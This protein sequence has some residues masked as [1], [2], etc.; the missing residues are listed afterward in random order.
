MNW[1]RSL[2]PFGVIF[3]AYGLDRFSKWWAADFLA[4]NGPTELHS[5]LSIKEAYNRGIAFGMFQGIGPLVGWL[6]IGV[7]IVLTISMLRL[8]EGSNL[9]KLG[10]SILIGGALG[11]MWDRIVHGEVL[12]FLVTPIRAGIF[13]VAD[14]LIYV[15][16]GICFIAAFLPEPPPLEPVG[17]VETPTEL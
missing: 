2:W 13:N 4:L 12:D 15:G 14:V 16:I 8:P 11:N 9:M 6:T 10:M 7:V 1:M 3:I 17:P 5:L